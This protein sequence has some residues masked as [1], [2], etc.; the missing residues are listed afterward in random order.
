[1][2]DS[3][4][5]WTGPVGS[6]RRYRVELDAVDSAV[7]GGEGIVYRAFDTERSADVALKMVTAVTLGDY[8]RLVARS[9]PFDAIDH[10]NLMSV[11]EVF[12]GPA[13][14][15]APNLE[16]DDFDVIYTVADWIEGIPL[17]EAA[18]DAGTAEL[19]SY[20]T[21]V[22]RG[23]AALHRHRSDAAPHGI[24]HRDVKPSNVRIRADGTA[25]LID[26]GVARPVA[27]D[28][29]TQ[30]VG[31][32]RWRAPEVLSGSAAISVAADV[33][34]V[35][36]VAYW[37]FTGQAP[38]L[39]G[40]GA[41]REQIAHSPRCRQLTDPVGV[42]VHIAALLET[43]PAKRPA[44]LARWADELESIISGKRRST[45]RRPATVTAAAL[46]AAV[47]ALAIAAAW[48]GD[49]S[50]GDRT[51]PSA[52]IVPTDPATE[53]TMPAA[54]TATTKA[55]V[56][57]I[58]S[59]PTISSS[60]APSAAPDPAT[61][62]G[63]TKPSGSGLTLEHAGA[64]STRQPKL[65]AF[66]SGSGRVAT[67]DRA[68]TGQG[69][70]G[71]GFVRIWD[72]AS[73]TEIQSGS[74]GRTVGTMVLNHD[75]T[76]LAT[77]TSHA[78]D[79]DLIQ[80]WDVAT[81]TPLGPPLESE[82]RRFVV[83]MEFGYEWDF[84]RYAEILAVGLDGDQIELWDV[85]DHEDPHRYVMENGA[86][87][88]DSQ[89]QAAQ[90][91]FGGMGQL[92]S[93]GYDGTAQQWHWWSGTPVG[94]PLVGHT[95]AVTSV[96]FPDG[97]TT[98]VTGSADGTIRVWNLA[99]GAQLHVLQPAG[100][101]IEVFR[102]PSTGFEAV[103]TVTGGVLH[104]Y[105]LASGDPIATTQAAESTTDVVGAAL[106]DPEDPDTLVLLTLDAKTGVDLWALTGG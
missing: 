16:I 19:L 13:L 78:S 21:G 49:P 37:A 28:D 6:S 7:P 91:A 45:W 4:V 10:P 61:E 79:G 24:L 34:G 74:V 105:D 40:A 41:A 92:A 60:S 70:Q 106:T 43:D 56:D 25:V 12:V 54:A 69:T 100:R 88:F 75:G 47:G 23:L 85:T 17:T 99:T 94:A 86:S 48:G 57:V 26:F 29:L 53:M 72:L 83:T 55:R 30:G 103:A 84:N 33:W 82:E 22:A 36:A 46:V 32:Y 98:L 2:P 67:A 95:A 18:P 27:D 15:D 80:L 51:T 71:D 8:G 59:Q 44:D 38:G 62:A 1:M 97:M 58:A 66:S 87:V 31:T 42:A 90:L 14:T 77:T 101:D 64:L 35:G 73:R 89:G 9:A 39:D 93:A 20:V 65:L 52:S 5:L 76:M 96:D 63:I 50:E 104:V 102:V 11:V 3:P 68:R 81:M